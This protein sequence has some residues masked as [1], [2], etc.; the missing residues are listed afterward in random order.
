MIKLWNKLVR[1]I[2]GEDISNSEKA[3]D[4]LKVVLLK[5]RVKIT[6]E[7]MT[8]I[9][10][11]LLEMINDYVQITNEVDLEITLER[12]GNGTSIVAAIP[13]KGGRAEIHSKKAQHIIK[14]A[15][16]ERIIQ[17]E[18][19]DEL[20]KNSKKHKKEKKKKNKEG[21]KQQPN[22][23]DNHSKKENT[24][25]NKNES[26]PSNSIKH[27]LH[28]NSKPNKDKSNEAQEKEKNL[29][30]RAKNIVEND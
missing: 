1:I 15:A 17:E 3:R 25:P 20:E 23:P 29:V 22:T 27:I 14:K 12:D 2:K 13:V 11:K 7:A 30:E 18:K 16:Q 24:H 5:D 4:R 6:P 21:N 19:Q 26:T 8:E 28:H 10:E 9:R